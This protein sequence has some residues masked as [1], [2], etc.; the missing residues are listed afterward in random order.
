MQ[1][2]GLAPRQDHPHNYA[3]YQDAMTT[4]MERL[5]LERKLAIIPRG[6]CLIWSANLVHGGPPA[7][8]GGLKR[9]SQVTHYF[10]RRSSYNWE[11]IMSDVS[12]GKVVYYDET[13][14]RRKWEFSE[15]PAEQDRL[16]EKSKFR[17]GACENHNGPDGTL[18]PC[19]LIHRVPLV[20]SDL[21]THTQ[22]GGEVLM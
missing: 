12:K 11:P 20:M 15:D 8:M 19:D 17:N 21:L 13:A 2:V 14:I 5:G 7:T 1:D 16:F 22:K 6:H 4:Y 18:S 10:Y 9:F 3:R